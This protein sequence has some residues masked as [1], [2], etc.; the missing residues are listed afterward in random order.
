MRGVSCPL[1]AQMEW[2]NP[3]GTSFLLVR[4]PLFVI[5]NVFNSPTWALSRQLERCSPRSNT[6]FSRAREV[7]LRMDLRED[8]ANLTEANFRRPCKWR[9]S[10]KRALRITDGLNRNTRMARRLLERDKLNLFSTLRQE[11][12]PLVNQ[13]TCE[14]RP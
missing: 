8:R 6:W 4:P 9:S 7:L 10:G 3:G 5:E 1:A 11:T 14:S 2:A 12:F 13:R